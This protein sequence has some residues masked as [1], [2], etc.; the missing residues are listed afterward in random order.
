[1]RL[2][3]QQS[4][5]MKGKDEPL[6]VQYRLGTGY[7]VLGTYGTS[8]FFTREGSAAFVDG[9]VPDAWLGLVENREI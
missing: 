2:L 8:F 1:M 9:L 7:W 6:N 4:N 3:K 5:R